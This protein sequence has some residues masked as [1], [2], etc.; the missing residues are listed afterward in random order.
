MKIYGK[1]RFER[2]KVPMIRGFLIFSYLNL[3]ANQLNLLK[4]RNKLFLLPLIRMK[5][6][7][8]NGK[9]NHFFNILNYEIFSEFLPFIM[10]RAYIL[11]AK[12]QFLYLT[13]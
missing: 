3:N 2:D 8:I 7:V 9:N 12:K 1:L 11:K 6:I 4:N 13:R 5:F 10:K